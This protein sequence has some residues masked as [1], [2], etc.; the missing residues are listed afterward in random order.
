VVGNRRGRIRAR[1]AART[2]LAGPVARAHL[3]AHRR[4]AILIL[5]A[6]CLAVA[7]AGLVVTTG[8]PPACYPGPWPGQPTQRAMLACEAKHMHPGSP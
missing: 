6:A 2:T 3:A 7:L 1:I 5:A 8:H 4:L